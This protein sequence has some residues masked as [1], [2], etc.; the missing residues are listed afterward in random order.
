ME[1]GLR[2]S[3]SQ[4]VGLNCCDD[5]SP[6][7]GLQLTCNMHEK[8]ILLQFNKI[9]NCQLLQAESILVLLEPEIKGKN[10]K[11]CVWWVNESNQSPSV[12]RSS[13]FGLQITGEML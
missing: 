2:W 11:R 12:L 7:A 3:L 4:S 10:V 8:E 1:H 6:F 13:R 5:Q 9:W